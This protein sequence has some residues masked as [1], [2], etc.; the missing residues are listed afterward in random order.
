M[1]SGSSV[2]KLDDSTSF[3]DWAM[4]MEALLEE[5]E[6]WD[7]VSGTEIAP[8]TGPNSKAS[9]AFARKLK[10]AK[11]K[12]ILHLDKSQLPHARF[13]TPK[14]IWDNLACIHR[15]R[16]F[17]T[18]LA[19]RRKF[20]NMHKLEE[21]SMQAWIASVRDAAYRLE[22][23]DFEVKD[24]DLII[25]L[26]QGLPEIYNSLIISLDATPVDKLTVE[27]VITRLLNE[28]YRQ[29]ADYMGQTTL[30]A[31]HSTK[32]FRSSKSSSSKTPSVAG[33]NHAPR[34]S[35]C[36]NC[37][38]KGHLARECPSPKQETGR[39]NL[40]EDASRSSSRASHMTSY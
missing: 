14:E 39:A 36:Y 21:Q 5:K 33:S 8:T 35:R 4:Q 34:S 2:D 31:K 25:A 38:G 32:S 15:T 7:V 16:G 1:G 12:I 3:T 13:D 22:S 9:K 19:M 24:I 10:L 6:L 17:G 18:L 26:T 37:G 40:A 11:A 23:A 29:T 30:M 27:A 28:E 20:F